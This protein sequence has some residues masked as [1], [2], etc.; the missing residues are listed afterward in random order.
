MSVLLLLLLLA[1][2]AASSKLNVPRVLLPY[3]EEGADFILS[4]DD[5]AGCFK[6][7]SSRPEVSKNVCVVLRF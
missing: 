5:R 1:W 6:W 2:S 7:K 4:S 3:S